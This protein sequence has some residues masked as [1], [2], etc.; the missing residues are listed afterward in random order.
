MSKTTETVS[1]LAQP[2]V[3]GQGLELVDV[4]YQKEGSDWI[5]RVFIENRNG[6]LTLEDCETVSKMLSVE[7]DEKDPIS[8]SYILEVS[9]PGIERPLKKPEDYLRF[10]GEKIKLKTYGPING[11]K[12]FVGILKNFDN[13]QIY[14]EN[15]KGVIEIP[16]KK[17]AEAHLN[18][19]L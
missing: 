9:S 12:E 17:V 18:V 5:L 8:Q 13:G 19:D 11:N 1:D 2:I 16:L 3:N 7:L 6:D 4:V 14:I 10:K 15:N